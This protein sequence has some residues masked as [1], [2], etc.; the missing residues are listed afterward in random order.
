M[1]VTA[2]PCKEEPAFQEIS[3]LLFLKWRVQIKNQ[4]GRFLI[5]KV[6]FVPITVKSYQ[7]REN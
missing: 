6:I 3:L 1:G 4:G 2:K 5:M 7:S